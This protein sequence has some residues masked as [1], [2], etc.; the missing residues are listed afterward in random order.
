MG[1]SCGSLSPSLPSIFL[2]TVD[3]YGSWRRLTGHRPTGR[4]R[5]SSTLLRES[6]FRG[7]HTSIL[8]K[9]DIHAPVVPLASKKQER[10]GEDRHHE[11]VE[12]AEVD[13]AGRD[14]D[15]VASIRDTKSNR[16]CVELKISLCHFA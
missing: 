2:T 5:G 14:T 6:P 8:G 11:Y 12:N 1:R 3:L 16:V 4:A 13:K 15:P 10:N 7:C 9:G